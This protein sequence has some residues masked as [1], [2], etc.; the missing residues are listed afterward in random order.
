MSKKSE[1]Q[2]QFHSS[3]TGRLFIKGEEFFKTKKVQAM[4]KKLLE[5]S[6]YKQIK[7]DQRVNAH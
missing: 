3:S 5:S 6:I 2:I 7:D 4:I 1:G